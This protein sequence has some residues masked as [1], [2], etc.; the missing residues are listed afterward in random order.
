MAENKLQKKVVLEAARAAVLAVHAAAGLAAA[1]S[2]D[3][4]RLLRSAEALSRSAVALLSTPTS[5]SSPNGGG[6][7]PDGPPRG[8]HDGGVPDG[9]PRR[10]RRRPRR[11]QKDAQNK[12]DTMDV[13]DGLAVA[14]AHGAGDGTRARVSASGRVLARHETLP[15]SPSPSSLSTCPP[16]TSP[17]PV[18]PLDLLPDDRCRL[19]GLTARPELNN[20][21]VRFLRFCSETGRCV[22]QHECAIGPQSPFRIKQENVVKIGGKD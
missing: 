20:T 5:K 9:P 6:S 8:A 1:H 21:F 3:A 13:D 2:R 7:A 22:V 14:C 18:F 11:S 10:P 17:T 12:K 4:V 16:S 19:V 15:P